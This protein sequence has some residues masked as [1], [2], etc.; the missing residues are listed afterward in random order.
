MLLHILSD[1]P[2]TC[3]KLGMQSEE[4][5]ITSAFT[6]IMYKRNSNSYWNT[7]MYYNILFNYNN[8]Y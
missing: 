2:G 6:E 7:V 8:I 5:S 3:L 1:I 4:V